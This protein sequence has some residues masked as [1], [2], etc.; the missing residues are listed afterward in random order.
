MNTIKAVLGLTLIGLTT[1]CGGMQTQL[2]TVDAASKAKALAEIQAH[3]K[4]LPKNVMSSV[5][6][7]RM[8]HK[9]YNRLLPSAREI[10]AH[11][12][13]QDTCHWD[14]DYSDERAFNAYATKENQIVVFHD[15]MTSVSSED[16]LA[17]V[18]AHEMGHHIGNHIEEFQNRALAGSLLMGAL[19]VAAQVSAGPCYSNCYQYQQNVGKAT[20]DAMQLGAAIGALTYSVSQEKESD[21]L[22]AYIL[23]RSGYDVMEAREVIV[24]L[25]VM[26]GRK[27]T[28]FFATHPAGPERLASF[29]AASEVILFDEDGLPDTPAELKERKRTLKQ[30]EKAAK[31]EAKLASQ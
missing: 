23:S 12:E 15:V 16:E 17:M 13:E 3:P 9:V 14:V 4:H 29:D 22:S 27:K 30:A 31:R 26:G 7:E 28:G 5:D 2:P 21:V 20:A 8:L 6:A 11:L 1:A 24:K 10:C 18:L 25:G 19:M